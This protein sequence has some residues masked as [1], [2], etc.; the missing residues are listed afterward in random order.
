MYDMA[1]R[2]VKG[3]VKEGGGREE[4]GSERRTKASR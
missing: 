3:M 2:A 1:E 4:K